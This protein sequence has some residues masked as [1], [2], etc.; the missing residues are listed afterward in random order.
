[1][2]WD[3]RSRLYYSYSTDS[4]APKSGLGKKAGIPVRVSKD[5]V[6]F[7]YRGTVLSP[8]AVKQG[9]DNG[10]YPDTKGFWAPYGEYENG[11]YRLYYSATRDF[12][13]SESRIWLAVSQDPMGPFE[14]RGV[15]V[16]SWGTDDSLP[17]AIDPHVLHAEGGRDYLVYGSFFGGIYMK[18]LCPETGM[19]VHPDPHFLGQRVA[20]KMPPLALDGPEGPAAMYCPET[21]YYYLFLS[22][23]WL[24]DNYD[25]R[26][27]R[28]RDP[29]GPYVDYEGRDLAGASLGLKLANSWIFRAR[30][31]RA[32]RG[33]GWQWGGFRGPGHGVPFRDPETGRY[34]FVHHVRDGNPKDCQYDPI[35][36]R[37]PD[38]RLWMIYG[39]YSGGIF[40]KEMDPV[41]GMPLEMDGY[42]EKLLGGN[43]LRIEAPY[44]VYNPD[45]GYYYLFLSF[46]GLDS[47]GGYNVRVVRSENPDGPYYDSMGQE[48][49]SCKGPS[50]SSFSDATAANYGV[51]LMG[52]YKF[53]WQEGELGEDRKGFLSPGHNSCLYD[54]ESGKYFMIHHTRFESRG[55]EHE[56]RVRQMFFNADGWPVLAPYRYAGE[57]A[58]VVTAEEIPGTYKLVNH[59]RAIT[60]EMSLSVNITLG[61]DGGISCKEDED[62]SG[63]WA[64]TGDSQAEL[65]IDGRTY[66][67]LFLVQWDE[68]GQKEVM[69]FTALDDETGMCVWGS[70]VK[71]R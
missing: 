32:K 37:Y 7:A 3:P 57:T 46:G 1:M 44:V 18:E 19:P 29:L 56:V 55:E 70:G 27:G 50:G 35:Y 49:T 22:Y 51:K 23:G 67:G 66:T 60:D 53:Q 26:V 5:L 12:G 61:K 16:D 31:P 41:T 48:M 64:L 14:N 54:E 71:A 62:L 38:G 28:S 36:D 4:Y 6:H 58:G 2:M 24:G 65:T 10:D 40:A 9:R 47:D 25:I 59:G 13:S 52:G 34:F 21:G 69:T 43:H 45:T 42:G 8:A 63:T 30:A 11:E 39:S 15:A 68:D 20:H 33:N 17:N